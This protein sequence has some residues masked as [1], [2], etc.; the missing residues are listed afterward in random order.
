LLLGSDR[1]TGGAT[2]NAIAGCVA[3]DRDENWV[4]GG[5]CVGTV[6]KVLRGREGAQPGPDG[7]GRLSTG[8]AAVEDLGRVALGR[9]TELA[10]WRPVWPK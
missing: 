9:M 10:S 1:A 3:P 8:G 2:S 7:G 4:P 5:A 6:V